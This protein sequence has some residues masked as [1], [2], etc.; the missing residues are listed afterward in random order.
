M[1]W[2]SSALLMAAVV[3]MGA[4]RLQSQSTGPDVIVGGLYDLAN[5]ASVGAVD[6]F[7]VGTES[8]NVGTQPL[9][10]QS[11]NPNHPVIAQNLYRLRNG[12]FE[13]V[14][15]S[16]LKH[17]FTALANSLCNT[18]Q[19]PGTG[20][21]LGVNCSDPYSAG[22]NGGQG[23]LG[24][25]HQVNAA[26]GAFIYPPASP[27]YSGSIA[28]RLQVAHA[29]LDPALNAG[30][31]YF[32]EGQ[33]VTPDDAAAGNKN[34]NASHRRVVFTGGGTNYD[35]GFAPG[36]TTVRTEPAIR[37]WQTAEPDVQIQTVDI[38]ND[39]RVYVA[40][41]ALPL[42]GAMRRFEFAVF[43]LSSDRGISSFSVALPGSA[44][45][46]GLYFHDVNYHS[47]E[48]QNGT[49][50]TPSALPGSVS[51]TCT[52]TVA[53][54]VNA[55]AIR[56]STM[57]NFA[58]ET[59][60]IPG[61]ATLG[62]FKTGT[63]TSV[64]VPQFSIPVA[65][66]MNNQPNSTHRL[67]GL[68]NNPF[69]GPIQASANG[70]QT[71]TYTMSSALTNPAWD[72]A[73]STLP[74]IANGFVTGN[75]QIINVNLTDPSL[76][77]LNSGFQPSLLGA[78]PITFPLIAPPVTLT[79]TTQMAVLDATHPDGT[80]LSAACRLDIVPCTPGNIPITLGDDANQVVNFGTPNFCD[81][82]TVSFA[83]T[84]YTR[85]FVNSN[86]SVTFLSGDDDFTPTIGDHNN[87]NRPRLAAYWTD[88]NPGV[89]GTIAA[90][91]N[92]AGVLTVSF[93]AIPTYG[94]PALVASANC[95][96]DTVAGSC[97]ITAY[98]PALTSTQET[99]VGFNPGGSAT[100]TAINWGTLVGSGLQSGPANRSLYRLVSGGP[101]VGFSSIT[102]PT[103]SAASF[104][105][106]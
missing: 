53:Q 105:V 97:A 24:P 90:T 70:G 66:W 93:S 15:M 27:S 50:W 28:R 6:A 102:F 98:S 54:N 76:F 55:N 79:L 99:L 65:A 10:W 20:A 2:T 104:I 80:S 13:Q 88:L 52:Q 21:L 25:R 75:G 73:V 16:W 34:N 29:D 7:S 78:M 43:N 18:C 23:P 12:R 8:C 71:A 87:T 57:Y 26:T 89:G 58:F 84:A 103:S 83:G 31:L 94:N 33:Y 100:A 19:N 37:A 77:F 38:P 49:D 46:G 45:A 32:V 1:K 17:G 96:F 39:G 61:V 48:L 64:Q 47:G 82:N 67:N 30:A 42:G 22:L 5:F 51:W 14:G 63:P 11:N 3:M 72:L 91:S 35:I 86:G 44:V 60:V 101:V 9:L 85:L 106:N 56:W 36:S 59:D 41:K 68:E 40:M 74:G 81:L 4:P 62:L 92:G 95:V 69:S